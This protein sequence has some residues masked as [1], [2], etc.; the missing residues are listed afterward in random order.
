MVKSRRLPRCGVVA[1]CACVTEKIRS[2]VRAVCIGKIHLMAGI[3]IRW[4]SC[5]AAARMALRTGRRCMCPRELEASQMMIE[6]RRLPSLRGM[7][8]GTRVAVI[9][10][11][12][13]WICRCFV[14]V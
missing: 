9:S 1:L 10:R 7:A 14:I 11:T 13:V 5:I 4:R 2:V 12:V 3:A 6:V 8:R